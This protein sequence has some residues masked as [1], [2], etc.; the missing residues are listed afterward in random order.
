M[1]PGTCC[2][3]FSGGQRSDEQLFSAQKLIRRLPL[4]VGVV[5]AAGD[6]EGG[7]EVRQLPVTGNFSG[8]IPTV[9]EESRN[10]PAAAN[11]P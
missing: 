7:S 11:E 3:P 1:L 2:H 4:F 9:I 10:Q 8:I 6:L 5:I